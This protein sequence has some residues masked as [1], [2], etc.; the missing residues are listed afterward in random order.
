MRR[1]AFIAGLG[2][3]AAEASTSSLI[4]SVTGFASAVPD[5]G[6]KAQLIFFTHAFGHVVMISTGVIKMP[7]KFLIDCYPK[8]CESVM[9]QVCVV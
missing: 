2:G 5:G 6:A 4:P 8:A 7:Q 9:K 3:T 1:R